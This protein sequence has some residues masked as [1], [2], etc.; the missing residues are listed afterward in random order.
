MIRRVIAHVTLADPH[1]PG[2]EWPTTRS[3]LGERLQVEVTLS[4]E[5]DTGHSIT[6]HTPFGLQGPKLGVGAIWW[7]Y[8]GPQLRGTYA[9]QV[10][11]LEANYRVGMHDIEDGINMMLGRDPGLQ[12]PPVLA[13]TSIRTALNA[14]GIDLTDEDLIT[15][16]LHLEFSN[17]VLAEIQST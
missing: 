5:D 1:P 17:E 2:V 8:H 13:W 3:G 11:F 7:R 12:K 14:V 6:S 15:I 9:E 10:D 4:A 16:P